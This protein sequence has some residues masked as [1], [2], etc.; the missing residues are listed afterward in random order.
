MWYRPTKTAKLSDDFADHKK[1]GSVNP[2]VDYP[3]KVGTEVKA[4]ADGKVV[5]VVNNIRGAG[6]R[7][8]LVKH[9]SY[10]TD[11]LHLS[12]I[13][14]KAGDV[15][16]AGDLLGLSGASG[17]GSEHHYGP[18]LHLS[19]RKGGT[20]LSGRGNLDFEKFLTT[21]NAKQVV[22]AAIV[23]SSPMQ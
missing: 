1:R 9:G 4:I 20:F 10:K 22:P 19:I 3:V 8:V 12:K 18:H 17:L 16:K 15:V 2:G 23:E 7:M 21:E 14:C 11:Y 13:L 5:K 6:G